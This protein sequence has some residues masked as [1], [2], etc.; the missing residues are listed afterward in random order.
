M[1]RQI[2]SVC[3]TAG[4]YGCLFFSYCY[5][6][7]I[8][9]YKA[10]S[11]VPNLIELKIL[12]DDMTVNNAVKLY[13]YF[14]IDATV[15]ISSEAPKDDEL[16]CAG[17]TNNGYKHWVACRKGNVVFNSLDH[18]VCVEKGKATDFRIIRIIK[19]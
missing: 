6:G 2:Q 13:E 5:I 15:S 11:N 18:S 8:D 3:K 12:K 7:G 10:L 16:Y 4:E 1:V 19:K 14:D 9:V 17:Y